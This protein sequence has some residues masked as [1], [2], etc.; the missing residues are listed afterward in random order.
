MATIS[1]VAKMAGVSVATVSRVINGVTTVSSEGAA[2]VRRAV[3]QLNYQPNSIGRTLRTAETHRIIVLQPSIA[4]PFYSRVVRGIDSAAREAGY[5]IMLCDT[6]NDPHR[7]RTYLGMLD[8]KVADGAIMITPTG[9]PIDYKDIANRHPLI[10]CCEYYDDDTLSSAT[11]DNVTAAHDAVCHLIDTGHRRIGFVSAYN[12]FLTVEQRF[13]GYKMALDE[14]GLPFDP[15]LYVDIGPIHDELIWDQSI[16]GAAVLAQMSNPPSAIFCSSD[17]VAIATIHA[18][19]ANG[20][21]VPED[22]S[23]MG[24]DDIDMAR[25]FDPG[26]STVYIPKK[27]IGQ[28]AVRLLLRRREDK[29][30]PYERVIVKHQ[31]VVRESSISI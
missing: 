5:Q 14:A 2:A 9:A 29:N 20:L 15:R 13:R 25:L 17:M 3:E 16:L 11:M 10:H 30:C 27:Q 8:S 31:I 6:D 24:F 28:E 26:L 4:N 12:K 7:E 21:R 22:I 23:V 18:I 19:K 1:D